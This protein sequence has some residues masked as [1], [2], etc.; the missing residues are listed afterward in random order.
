MINDTTVALA[1]GEELAAPPSALG[2]IQAWEGVTGGKIL[3]VKGT[4]Q[5]SL[6]VLGRTENQT[7]SRPRTVQTDVKTKREEAIMT[8]VTAPT[9][10]T[11]ETCHLPMSGSRL[12]R[13]AVVITERID[14]KARGRP[15]EE[16]SL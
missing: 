4:K 2:P 12:R 10:M 3:G 7:L 6:S 1:P 9:E 14:K 13:S 8:N 16:M 15:I 5:L 11:R